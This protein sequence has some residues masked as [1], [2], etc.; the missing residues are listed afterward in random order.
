M[1]YHKQGHTNNKDLH[2]GECREAY[3]LGFRE[4]IVDRSSPVGLDVGKDQ[5]GEVHDN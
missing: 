2:H 4:F 3:V 5:C 1:D